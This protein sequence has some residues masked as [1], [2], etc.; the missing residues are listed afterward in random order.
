MPSDDLSLFVA[1]DREFAIYGKETSGVNFRAIPPCTT[2]CVWE[3]VKGFETAENLKLLPSCQP[4]ANGLLPLEG[5]SKAI[6]GLSCCI[7]LFG[8]GLPGRLPDSR[9][10]SAG[11]RQSPRCPTTKT[12]RRF[13]GL[14]NIQSPAP[15]TPQNT[16]GSEA[17]RE[18]FQNPVR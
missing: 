11:G 8:S 14:R 1:P 16:R 5:R 6:W 15:A 18:G 12:L 7:F 9:R 10:T 2:A 4:K 17:P 13:W 3:I